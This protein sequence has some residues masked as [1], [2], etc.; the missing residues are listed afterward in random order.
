[1]IAHRLST[2]RSADQI[3]VLEHGEIVERGTH[4]ELLALN[5]RYRQLYDKQYRFE[6]RPVH[7][8]R[9]GLHARAGG[10]RRP[11]GVAREQRPVIVVTTLSRRVTRILTDPKSEWA[12]IAAEDDDVG[13]LYRSYIAILAAVPALSILAGLA[14]AGG[15]F[16]GA[17]GITTAVTA[18]TVSYTMALASPIVIAVV[19]EKVAPTFK[20]DGS[21][22]QALKLVAYSSTPIWLVGVSSMLIVLS[23]LV[24]VGW[25]W[26]IYLFYLGLPPVMKT[27]HEQVMPFMLV[28]ALATIVVNIILSALF[29]AASIPHY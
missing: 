12:V 15:R 18:A 21:M 27:P 6:Q 16:L 19:V 3:L 23:P 29:T 28:S 20:A 24:V 5:G 8:S 17:A 14:L 11:R 4:E 13:S 1:M 22:A 2:I 9:R 7:Q 10:R 25:L 26:A